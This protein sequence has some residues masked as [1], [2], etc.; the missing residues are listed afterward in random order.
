MSSPL[1]VSEKRI[2]SSSIRFL[3]K[4]SD[5]ELKDFGLESGT[6]NIDKLS[7]KACRS[8]EKVVKLRY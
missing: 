5:M 1:S 4:N 6:I 3:M 2:L 7:V 8:L